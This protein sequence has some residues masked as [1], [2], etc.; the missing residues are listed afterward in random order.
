MITAPVPGNAVYWNDPDDGACSG[1]YIVT[2]V[3]VGG[4]DTVVSLR[5]GYGSEVEAFLSELTE[6]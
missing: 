5:N 4:S 2:G 6:G 1:H 3:R